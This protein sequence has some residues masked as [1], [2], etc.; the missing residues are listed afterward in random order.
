[1]KAPI[2]PILIASC[3]TGV[4]LAFISGSGPDSD[5]GTERRTNP[6]LQS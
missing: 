2:R 3:L 4:L 6:F 1:M 5:L